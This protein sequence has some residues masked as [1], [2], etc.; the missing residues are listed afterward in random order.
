[1]SC[2]G[3]AVSRRSRRN[4]VKLV[5]CR[6]MWDE[7]ERDGE[8]SKRAVEK[9]MTSGSGRCLTQIS[10]GVERWVSQLT[11]GPSIFPLPSRSTLP[12]S[13]LRTPYSS[14]LTTSSFALVHPEDRGSGSSESCFLAAWP[15]DLHPPTGGYA[16]AEPCDADETIGTARLERA[17]ASVASPV[18]S[19]KAE[20]SLGDALPLL[21]AA[22]T[23]KRGHGRSPFRGVASIGTSPFSRTEAEIRS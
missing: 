5:L 22:A 18:G 10:L 19:H 2:A 8:E 17:H 11:G 20:P 16:C 1:M 12:L 4:R 23:G 7:R 13:A 9:D 15:P 14:N 6:R 3:E 21:R